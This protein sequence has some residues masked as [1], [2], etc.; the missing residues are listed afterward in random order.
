[1][2]GKTISSARM[3]RIEKHAVEKIGVPSLILMENAGRGLAEEAIR[4]LKSL[5]IPSS[6]TSIAIF[7]GSGNNAGDGFVAAR[8]LFNKGFRPTVI[9]V[10]NAKKLKGDALLNYSIIKNLG[11]PSK[12]FAR[13][14]LCG[15]KKFSLIVDALLGTGVKGEVGGFYRKAIDY[16]N[17]SGS[18][19]IS[20]DIPSG[21][22]ADTGKPHGAAVRADVTVAM[23]ALKTGLVKKAAKEFVG[24]L[25]VADIGIV[26][27]R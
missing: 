24:K 14:S 3:R 18:K 15:K 4:L 9:L 27:R 2:T 25:K 12:N 13:M 21:L 23:G 22:D 1:M 10:K 19:V 8:H 17:Q 6:R 5:K 20:A 16:I 26:C 11:I 7:C